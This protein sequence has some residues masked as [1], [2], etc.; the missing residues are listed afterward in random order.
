MGLGGALPVAPSLPTAVGT[1]AP[2]MPL[3]PVAFTDK[4]TISNAS[5]PPLSTSMSASSRHR[6][7]PDMFAPYPARPSRPE[8]SLKQILPGEST[9][10]PLPRNP[11]NQPLPPLPQHSLPTPYYP[12]TTVPPLRPH[13]PS[14][15]SS[16]LSFLT[17]QS[18]PLSTKYVPTPSNNYNN[19][20]NQDFLPSTSSSSSSTPTASPVA[21]TALTFEDDSNSISPPPVGADEEDKRR[22]N[23]AASARFRAKKKLREQA[24]ERMARE[25]SVKTDILERKLVG[26]F[27]TLSFLRF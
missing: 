8:N 1:S 22:R 27:S 12:G 20:N 10:K 19:V 26:M 17:S 18:T 24:M 13:L 11:S 6:L 2:P 25:M 7:E 5:I 15:D 23:T 9:L 4:P 21:A 14:D 16:Y 3:A